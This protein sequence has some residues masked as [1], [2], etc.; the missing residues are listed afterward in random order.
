M[1]DLGRFLTCLVTLVLFLGALDA[2]AARKLKDE[3]CLAC[4]GDSTLTQDVN[5]KPESLY[6]DQAKL[7]HSVHGA[8]FSCVDCH[9]DVKSL[10]H[11]Q[12]PK[13]IT[14]AQC[15]ADAQQ[16]YA[17]SLHAKAGKPGKSIPAA[18]C[19]DCHGG[20]HEVLASDDPKSPV[21]HANI[22]ATCGRCHGQKFLMESNGQSAQPFFSYQDSVHGRAVENGSQ[23]AA[24][25]TDCHGSAR[26]SR[27]QRGA[28]AH[29]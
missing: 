20:A 4:H 14:C 7:K 18:T 1:K 11:E 3:D 28:I 8:M 12:P 25:C 17:H 16:A 13:K 23:K 22:P 26:D 15:H 19:E 6:V 10:A 2:H 21:N 24:V 29:L 27:G 9:T 5:G